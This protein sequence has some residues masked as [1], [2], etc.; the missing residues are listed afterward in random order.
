MAR[1][2][3]KKQLAEFPA[4]DR[5]RFLTDEEEMAIRDVGYAFAPLFEQQVVDAV[6]GFKL[7]DWAFHTGT[8]RGFTFDVSGEVYLDPISMTGTL[9]VTRHFSINL[10][11][12]RDAV[13]P[14]LEDFKVKLLELKDAVNV[15]FRARVLASEGMQQ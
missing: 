15:L 4:F 6:P 2:S 9:T 7:T 1:R 3:L 13:L 8:D 14:M 10:P 5:V 11:P 12:T